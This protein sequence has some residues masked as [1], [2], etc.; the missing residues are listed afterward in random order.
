MTIK[1]YH[2]KRQHYSIYEHSYKKM[3][4]PKP[5]KYKTIDLKII[6]EDMEIVNL[7]PN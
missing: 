5:Q 7:A 1:L 2:S 4:L 6:G 3:E